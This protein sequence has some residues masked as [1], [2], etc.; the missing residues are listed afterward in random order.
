MLAPLIAVGIVGQVVAAPSAADDEN[1]RPAEHSVVKT[2]MEGV[3]AIAKS[4]APVQLGQSNRDDA[5]S[6]HPAPAAVAWVHLSKDYLR[7]YVERDV[8]RKKPA[9]ENVLGIVFTGNSQTDGKT[10]LVLRPNEQH[11]TA[12]VEFD[13]TVRSFTV[14]HSGP[15]TLQYIGESTFQAHK[16]LVFGEDGVSATRALVTAPTRLIP[17]NVS[18]DLPGLRGRI[19][20]R[21]AQR[22]EAG[23]RAE[24]EA[25]VSRDT[26]NDIRHDFDSKLDQSLADIQANVKAQIAALNLNGDN[27]AVVM[28]SRSTADFVEVALCPHKADVAQ[29]DLAMAS[30]VDG[31][32]D[33]SV[34][35]H[36]SVVPAL[37]ANTELR[38]KFAPML[39]SALVISDNSD[40]AATAPKLSLNGDW[41]AIDLSGG[42]LPPH[43][44]SRVAA[45][46][47]LSSR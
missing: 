17:T 22:R 20:N 5:Q 32:P 14:G 27:G 15:A 8:D 13:G 46:Q 11:A 30:P 23:S 24:A 42:A 34:C 3:S 19:G 37:L 16:Q 9:H 10:R 43:V 44:S 29:F 31:N 38:E 33:C 2:A 47:S 40:H 21:I 41:I 18:T 6:A 26:A 28:R 12:E 36:R 39:T 35:I 4:V 1:T 7:K 25:I 45:N